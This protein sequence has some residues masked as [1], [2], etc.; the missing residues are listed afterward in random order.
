MLDP[1]SPHFGYDTVFNSKHGEFQKM[2]LEVSCE[3]IEILISRFD[4]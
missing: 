1:A 3:M 4:P 2:G